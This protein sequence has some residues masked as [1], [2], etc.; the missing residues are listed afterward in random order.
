MLKFYQ[1][2]VVAA[3]V[4]LAGCGGKT[5]KPIVVGSQNGTAQTVVGEIVAQHLEHR[6][7]RKIGRTLGAANELGVYQLLLAGEITL[8]PTFTGNIETLII[9]E[10][11]S[12]DPSV[13]W[14]RSQT[15]MS[16]TAH[17][18]LFNPLGYENPPAMVIRTADAEAG[19][20]ATLGQAAEGKTQWKIGVSY[21]FQQRSD[22]LQ[23]LSSY[24]LPMSQAIRGMEA[25]QLFPSLD[26]GDLTMIAA[27]STDGHLTLPNYRLLADDRHAFT[28]NQACLLV[29]QD[30][31]AAEPAMR[32]YLAELSGKFTTEAVRKMSAEVELDHRQPAEVAAAF[33]A[34]AGLK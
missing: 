29:R 6:M 25:R 34:Q 11:P 15:E 28:P 27:D 17:L 31:L 9:R 5:I 22:A 33:L 18:D 20:A 21:E 30:T 3:A 1:L 13:V 19:N 23:A 4:A 16:R 2:A 12:S 7:A 24:K 8:Y 32:A 14:T 26:K 10:P